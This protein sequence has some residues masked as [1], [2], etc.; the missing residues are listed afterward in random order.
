MNSNEKIL[1]E[2]LENTKSVKKIVVDDVVEK[3]QKKEKSS[4]RKAE[5]KFK[6]VG[7]KFNESE[8]AEIKS[9][10]EDLS[11]NQSQ[12]IKKLIQDDL[13]PQKSLDEDLS[14]TND[15]EV[16]N[17]DYEEIKAMNEKLKARVITL[18]SE[19]DNLKNKS[20][21]LRIIEEKKLI[22]WLFLPYMFFDMWITVSKDI[23]SKKKTEEV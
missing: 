7:A 18:I 2:I 20:I 21:Y 4:Q 1:E 16:L 6:N 10:L 15:K 8:Q 22:G 14:S 11:C 23:K 19:K 9:R 13:R 5:S 3:K 12:Y 17:D